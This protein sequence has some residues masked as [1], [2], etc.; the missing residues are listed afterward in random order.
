[1]TKLPKLK[2]HLQL[3]HHENTNFQ[4][5]NTNLKHENINFKYENTTVKHKKNANLQHL[6]GFEHRTNFPQ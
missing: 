4:H 1:M 2:H 6:G 5:D 3:K